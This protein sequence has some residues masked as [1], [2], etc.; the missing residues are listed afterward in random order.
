LGVAW[1]NSSWNAGAGIGGSTNLF[2][3]LD[4]FDEGGSS[5]IGLQGGYNYLLPN[6]ILLGAEIDASFPAWPTLPTCVNPF[7]VSIGGSSTFTGTSTLAPA[8]QPNR[9]RNGVSVLPVETCVSD[10]RS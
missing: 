1:G 2:Q 7:G 10:C 3:K 4:T 8:V 5:F 6:R 9:H